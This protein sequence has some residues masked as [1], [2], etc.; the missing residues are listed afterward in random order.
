MSF[1]RAAAT[2][3]GRPRRL[4][5]RIERAIAL[6]PRR[7]QRGAGRGRASKLRC[8]GGRVQTASTLPAPAASMPSRAAPSAAPAS[9]PARGRSSGRS[10][11][12]SSAPRIPSARRRRRAAAG[13]A[14]RPPR[15]ARRPRRRRRRRRPPSPRR[16][17]RRRRARRASPANMPVASA[18]LC[19]VRSP[20]R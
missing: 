2:R 3:S 10:R 14:A 16:P 20:L 19:G 1:P 15:R 12:R 7:V 18:S 4:L 17:A 5:R 9:A 13:P 6:E 11:R 8:V